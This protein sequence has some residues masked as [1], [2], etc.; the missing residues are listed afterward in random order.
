MSASEKAIIF[1]FIIAILF[2]IG[3]V[4]FYHQDTNEK[5]A[6]VSGHTDWK[7]VMWEEKDS[8]IGIGPDVVEKVLQDLNIKNNIKYVG[9]W[10]VVQSKAK[11]GEIDVIVAL[12]KTK[13]R[14]DYLYYSVPY[15]TDPIAVFVKNNRGFSLEKGKD[16]LIGKKGVATIGDSY[17]Q[18]IDNAITDKELD[19]TRVNTPQEAFTLIEK[20]KYDY[21]LYSLYSGRKVISEESFIQIK[22]LGVISY[23]N[24]YI[25]ISKKSFIADRIPEIN[26]LLEKYKQDGTIENISLKYR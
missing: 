2:F 6:I 20:E 7:P 26:N 25:G 12:Y 24:F 11:T 4:V 23:Q 14:E 1:A 8:I 16:G 13:E 21:F 3:M 19:V 9:T 17:G 5:I 22:E 15:T 10:D 18:E